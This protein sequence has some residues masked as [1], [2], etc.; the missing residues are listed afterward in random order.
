MRPTRRASPRGLP[1]TPRQVRPAS[2]CAD[3]CRGLPRA[4][5]AHAAPWGEGRRAAA[6]GEK[7]TGPEGGHGNSLPPTG[8]GT[9]TAG[10]PSSTHG[11]GVGGGRGGLGEAESCRG[12]P[13]ARACPP[14]YSRGPVTPE[15]KGLQWLPRPHGRP[16]PAP[17]APQSFQREETPGNK[18]IW[19]SPHEL[20]SCCGKQLL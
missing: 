18:I 19:R 11:N 5:S 12:H 20:F 3:T 1:N 2:A 17:S 16:T 14:G 13:A 4:V 9:S 6:G 7:L 10:F 15:P 8:L